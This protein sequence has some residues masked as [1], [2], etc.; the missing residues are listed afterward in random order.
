MHQ[1][2]YN[3]YT[4]FVFPLALETRFT[5]VQ[6]RQKFWDSL[7]DEGLPAKDTTHFPSRK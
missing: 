7:G 3:D 5:L 1:L 6:N 2:R 4:F